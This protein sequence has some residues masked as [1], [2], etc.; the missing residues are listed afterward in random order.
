MD[1]LRTI[2]VYM[3]MVFVSSVQNAPEP[4][5]MPPS[6]PTPAAYVVTTP[7][8]TPTPEPTPSPTPV[9]TPEITPNTEY[10]TIK[11]G[12]R[13]DE[14]KKLQRRLAELGYYTGDIDGSYGNQT[15]RAVERFQYYHGLSAD[16]IA[17]KN[18][19]TV[20]YEY[21]DVVSAPVDVPTGGSTNTPPPATTR[22]PV[23]TDQPTT[24]R[25]P[26][27]DDAT[28]A[29]TFIPTP[30][31]G[32]TGTVT[33]DGGATKAPDNVQPATG[34]TKAPGE[35][36]ASGTIPPGAT[37]G[38][39]TSD[40]PVASEE[41][42]AEAPTETPAPAVPLPMEGYTFLL[43]GETGPVT[44]P[45]ATGQPEGDEPP[46]T[47]LQLGED[48]VLVP[49][50][51]I[52]EAAKVTVVPLVEAGHA[53]YAFAIGQDLYR[54]SYDFDE[55]GTVSKL[56]VDKN[57]Q[58]QLMTQRVAVI[59]DGTL[60]LSLSGVQEWTGITFALD[61]ETLVYTVAFPEES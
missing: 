52:L 5:I 19:L 35:E 18:T 57:S 21:N 7:S 36:T 55:A 40:E 17:G 11:V 60:Y 28:L 31:P 37:D 46:A 4:T 25:T 14:V 39:G 41:P 38:P 32:A 26:G 58:P 48:V 12:D 54:V 45:L 1:L 51:N 16:G 43:E 23:K 20:L 44:M 10:K 2:L 27:P 42:T 33:A 24:A 22:P 50:L 59:W 34:D 9:P 29:P 8:P 61:E 53:E 15:R 13:G 47:P 3:S 30:T 56:V 6:T 49:F